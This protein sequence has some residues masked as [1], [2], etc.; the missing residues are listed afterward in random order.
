MTTDEAIAE[1]INRRRRQVWVHSILYYKYDMNLITDAIWSKWAKE[2]VQ[3]QKD[4]P[5]IS[6]KVEYA[7]VFRDFDYSTGSTLPL[8]DPYMNTVAHNLMRMEY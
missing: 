7:D 3:L 5:D 1:L 2:L 6:E 4:Y 8:D